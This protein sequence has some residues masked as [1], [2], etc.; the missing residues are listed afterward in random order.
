[1]IA[2]TKSHEGKEIEVYPFGN[3][4]PIGMMRCRLPNGN[5]IRRHVSRLEFQP[6]QEFPVVDN[7]DEQVRQ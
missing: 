3:P 2:K 7:D 1:M 6:V 5:I 4:S